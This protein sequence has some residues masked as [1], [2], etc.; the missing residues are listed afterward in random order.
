[1]DSTKS[2]SSRTVAGNGTGECRY[3]LL[4]LFMI[5]YL[6]QGNAARPKGLRP[7]LYILFVSINSR[8]SDLPGMESAHI[9]KSG[10]LGNS[11]T[12]KGHHHCGS[13]DRINW[14]HSG[15]TDL[16]P[17]V[18]SWTSRSTYAMRHS[19]SVTVKDTGARRLILS[20]LLT[21]WKNALERI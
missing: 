5:F 4:F 6:I 8:P 11:A 9:R 1:M 16:S 20:I 13:V 18:P 15:E 14:L 3:F 7:F 12:V 19:I 2:V 21:V 17:G 10:C